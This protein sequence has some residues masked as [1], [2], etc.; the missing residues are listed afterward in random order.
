MNSYLDFT[1]DPA[2]FAQPAMKSFVDGLHQSGQHYVVIV[3]PGIHN[4]AAYAPYASGLAKNLF[5]K[6]ADGNTFIG[7]VSPSEIC[8][9][10][11]PWG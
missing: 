7:K 3:D 10:G 1:F 9:V 6:R 11:F 2:R 4:D 5:V 8:V